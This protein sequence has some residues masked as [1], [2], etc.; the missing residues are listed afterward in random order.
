MAL[1]LAAVAALAAF[2]APSRRRLAVGYGGAVLLLSAGIAIWGGL[3][4][5]RA[6]S[7]DRDRASTIKVACVQGNIPQDRK[8]APEEATAILGRHLEL[9]REAAAE[10]AT[11]IVWPESSLPFVL[12]SSPEFDGQVRDL[13]R[14]LG[15]PLVIGSLDVRR[16]PN[17]DSGVYNAAFLI[18]GDGVLAGSYDKVHL[19]PFGEY[20]PWRWALPFASS[21]VEGVGDV[22]AGSG[23][24]LLRDADV[25]LPPLG[26]QICFEILFPGLVRRAVADGAELLIN[27]TNDAWFG[28]SSA[29]HQ[30]FAE[31]VVRAVESDR[32]VVRAANTGISGIIAPTGQVVARSELGHREQPARALDLGPQLHNRLHPLQSPLRRDLRD[33]VPDHDRSVPHRHPLSHGGLGRR[34]RP[35]V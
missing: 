11:L 4:T 17:G 12:R 19:V 2:G 30:H 35:F 8:W 15:V 5:S 20:V 28:R 23:P 22:R 24:R 29:P 25:G 26:V 16:D 18:G 6:G 21:L 13:A 1:L 27:L 3:R 10:G 34:R 14:G 9:S 7:L 31:A 33:V 32:W